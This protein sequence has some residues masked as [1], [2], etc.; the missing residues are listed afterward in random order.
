[1]ASVQAREELEAENLEQSGIRKSS[2]A[3]AV[4]TNIL[5]VVFSV[6]LSTILIHG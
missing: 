1:V 2:T 3:Y 4:H 6:S 5:E